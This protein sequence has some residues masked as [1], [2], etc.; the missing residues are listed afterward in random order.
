MAK[1]IVQYKDAE[2][3][4]IEAYD[5]ET[6]GDTVWFSDADGATLAVVPTHNVLIIRRAL[7]MS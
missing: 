3:S 7:E 1:W 6:D 2:P 4:I 5:I